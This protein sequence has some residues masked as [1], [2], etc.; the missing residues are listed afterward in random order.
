MLFGGAL[1]GVA[2]FAWGA[3]REGAFGGA[4]VQALLFGAYAGEFNL[5]ADLAPLCK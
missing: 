3:L 2:G 1:Q 4:G 5:L